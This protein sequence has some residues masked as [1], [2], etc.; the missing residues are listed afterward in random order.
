MKHKTDSK[1]NF[2][3]DI[4]EAAANKIKEIISEKKMKLYLRVYVHTGGCNGFRYGFAFD[5]SIS[6]NDIKFETMGISL[7][8]DRKSIN[9][10][11]GGSIDYIDNLEESYFTI[12]NPN[13]KT[14]CSCGFSFCI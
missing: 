14:T 8:V 10:I 9:Y 1:F 12:I 5:E 4:T 13:A 3:I 11:H 6:K 2:F 7:L